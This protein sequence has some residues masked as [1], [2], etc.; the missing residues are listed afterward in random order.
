MHP[1]QHVLCRP[2]LAEEFSFGVDMS[3]PAIQGFA[4][5]EASLA[6][7]FRSGSGRQYLYFGPC[8]QLHSVKQTYIAFCRS[9]LHGF[10]SELF[11]S[12]IIPI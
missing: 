8:S 11:L 2:R 3:N 5:G 9:Q 12:S 4:E 10:L 6:V 1:I 7:P